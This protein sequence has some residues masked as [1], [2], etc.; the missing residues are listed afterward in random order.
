M[1]FVG[2]VTERVLPPSLSIEVVGYRYAGNIYLWKKLLLWYVRVTYLEF[3]SLA[4]WHSLTGNCLELL[5]QDYIM[6]PPP[7]RIAADTNHCC[8]ALLV[9]RM[10]WKCNKIHYVL[11]HL[12]EHTMSTPT[13]PPCANTKIL[14]CSK[15][16][17]METQLKVYTLNH[18]ARSRI[19][20]ALLLFH[21]RKRLLISFLYASG[22]QTIWFGGSQW[23]G[24]PWI[25]SRSEEQL[26]AIRKD[27]Q[28]PHPLNADISWR[29]PSTLSKMSLHS[30][31]Q[32]TSLFKRWKVWVF[33][34]CLILS[35][36]AENST[37]LDV[38][39]HNY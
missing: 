38:Q 12:Q 5:P 23:W 28:K 35:N 17:N 37:C 31:D 15:F 27:M 39:E 14:N 6:L 32:E 20:A 4:K 21:D 22:I 16:C 36:T 24:E 19:G 7:F 1:V 13:H 34:S 2:V 25:T 10:L 29:L 30:W 8:N 11:H 26:E 18:S 33:V 9:Q 3:S